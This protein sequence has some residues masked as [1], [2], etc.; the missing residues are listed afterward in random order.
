MKHIPKADA[1]AFT[2]RNYYLL[3]VSVT[4][5]YEKYSEKTS[6]IMKLKVFYGDGIFFYTVTNLPSQSSWS[7]RQL[8]SCTERQQTRQTFSRL[9]PP[10]LL[11][12]AHKTNSLF[13]AIIHSIYQTHSCLAHVI[14]VP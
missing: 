12:P 1:T 2:V 7:P 11:A 4:Q 6:S 9:L 13:N 10:R 14:L 3:Q 8:E 5:Y